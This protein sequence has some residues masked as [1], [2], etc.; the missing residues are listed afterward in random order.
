MRR[1][2]ILPIVVIPIEGF[3]FNIICKRNLGN[4][5]RFAFLSAFAETIYDENGT[6]INIT[7]ETYYFNAKHSLQVKNFSGYFI[8]Q[9]IKLFERH[10][11]IGKKLIQPAKFNFIGFCDNVTSI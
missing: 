3:D 9:R 10:A 4:S 7:N 8:Y 5:F 1:P 11:S 6:L 2:T